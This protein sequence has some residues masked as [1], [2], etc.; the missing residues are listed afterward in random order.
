MELDAGPQLE[1]VLEA[2][3]ADAPA[4]GE[5]RDDA[6]VLA[7]RDQPLEHVRG[8]LAQAERR[9]HVGIEPREVGVGG[10]PQDLGGLRVCRGRPDDEAGE[11]PDDDEGDRESTEHGLSSGERR[12]SL[13]RPPDRPCASAR[14]RARPGYRGRSP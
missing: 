9:A 11:E 2:V 14:S 8:Q 13:P 12:R 3:R 4:L 10:D 6:V 7:D 5:L 1:R